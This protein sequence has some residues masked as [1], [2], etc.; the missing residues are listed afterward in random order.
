MAATRRFPR[1]RW[2][3]GDLARMTAPE[4]WAPLLDGVGAVVN[5]AGALQDNARD[6]LSGVHVTGPMALYRACEA[7][8]I[9]RVIHVSAGGIDLADTA[10]ARTKREA[11]QALKGTGLDWLI[12]RPGLVMAP[13]AYGGTALVRA[14]AAFPF[15]VP[16]LQPDQVMQVVSADDVAE[17]VLRAL[18]PDAPT[19]ATWDVMHPEKTTLRDIFTGYREW[20]GLA[21]APVMRMPAFL[22]RIMA[23]GADAVAWLGW[24]SPMRTTSL[25]QLAAGVTG[26]PTR[27]MRDAGIAPKSLSE[28]FAHA[29]AGVQERWFARLYLLKPIGIF[30]IALFWLFSGVVAL[31]PGFGAGETFLIA[32]GMAPRLAWWTTLIGG[33]VDIV[34][35]TLVLFRRIHRAV[36]IAM[37]LLCVVYLAAGSL[38]HP[39]FWLDPLGVY[40]KVVP[41]MLAMAMLA[42]IADE[43]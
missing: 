38:L 25:K 7:R 34:L 27:W 33:W 24:R 11:E 29:P 10:F 35:G 28:V 37:I 15:V 2:V 39:E 22:A 23:W 30:V 41:I 36:L 13:A 4:D 19:R 43:R 9:R 42:A 26:D 6:A 40:A 12:L 1:V 32:G 21:R 17:T 18:S 16:V 5:C 8:G 31:G 3:A 20:L 14:L